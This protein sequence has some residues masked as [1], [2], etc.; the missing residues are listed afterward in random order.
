[1][2]GV[3]DSDTDADADSG[4]TNAP[5]PCAE[6]HLLPLTDDL[7]LISQSEL[8]AFCESS[9][10]VEGDLFIGADV[11]ELSDLSCLCEVGG[12]FGLTGGIGRTKP[13]SPESCPS[14]SRSSSV[15]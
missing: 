15:A 13:R 14:P 8:Q 5:D 3:L 12:D 7:F 1:M 10:G 9:N 11:P 4:T 2:S 6:E